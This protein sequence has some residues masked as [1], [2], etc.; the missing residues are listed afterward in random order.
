MESLHLDCVGP[1]RAIFLPNFD[2]PAQP[3]KVKYVTSKS[4]PQDD[5]L[6]NSPVLLLEELQNVLSG[7][8]E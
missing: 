7:V 4:D 5:V 3:N 2:A 1:I 6:G 8:P